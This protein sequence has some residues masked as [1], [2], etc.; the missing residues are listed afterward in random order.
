MVCV[1]VQSRCSVVPVPSPGRPE[2]P[3][4]SS[5]HTTTTRTTLTN[6]LPDRTTAI[7]TTLVRPPRS[8]SLS[9]PEV[10]CFRLRERPPLIISLSS[11]AALSHSFSP[12]SMSAYSLSSLNMSTLPRNMY[13]TSPRGTLMR[14]KAKKKDFKSSRESDL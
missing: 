5:P 1:C 13:P 3:P 6:Q 9:L 7:Q 11:S 4:L 8:L 14:R 2:V 12:G 10:C